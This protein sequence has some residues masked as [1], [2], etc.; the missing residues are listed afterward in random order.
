MDYMLKRLSGVSLTR[1]TIL[2][3]TTI[4]EHGGD[5]RADYWWLTPYIYTNKREGR[6][7]K[8]NIHPNYSFDIKWGLEFG[9]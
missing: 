2:R 9:F 7:R 3:G 4:G 6:C 5:M 8:A 1:L